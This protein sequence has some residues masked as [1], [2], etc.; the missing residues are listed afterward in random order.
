MFKNLSEKTKLTIARTIA[1]FILISIGSALTWIANQGDSKKENPPILEK[2]VTPT[3]TPT[4]VVSS[5]PQEITTN[6]VIANI[7]TTDSLI[8]KQTTETI[9]LDLVTSESKTT[10]EVVDILPDLPSYPEETILIE[11]PEED[12]PSLSE[13]EKKEEKNEEI[14]EKNVSNK[15]V[16]KKNKEKEIS[17]N[18]KVEEKKESKSKPK[19][20]PTPKPVEIQRFAVEIYGASWCPACKALNA[21]MQQ[22]GYVEGKDYNYIDIERENVPED[23]KAFMKKNGFIPVVQFNGLI[24]NGEALRKYYNLK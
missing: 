8:E 17:S 21:Q 12:I 11:T 18:N 19:A 24:D 9:D 14:I 20:T 23:V 15:Q 4:P 10:S 6:T 3:P 13:N 2:V 7:P 5:L 22:R 16:D 1:I